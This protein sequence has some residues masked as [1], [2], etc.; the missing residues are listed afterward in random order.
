MNSIRKSVKK[1]VENIFQES[2][3]IGILVGQVFYYLLHKPFR[4]RMT[5]LEM[6]NIGANSVFIVLLTGFFTGMV[7]ALET[8]RIFMRFQAEGTVGSVVAVAVLR[9]IGPVMCS[10][11]IT[12]RAGS[13][14]AA[15]IG[16]M[17]VTQQVD[18]LYTMAVEP[19]S[20]L[21]V[22][23]IIASTLMLPLLTAMFDF[24]AI[25]GSWMVSVKLLSIGE[26]IFFDYI[27]WLVDVED[28]TD[29]L[30]KSCFFGF[31]IAAICCYN[32]LQTE[33]GALGV[34]KSTTRAV[35]MS[36]VLILVSDYFLTSLLF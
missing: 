28:I 9:E 10:L 12:A 15:Q 27:E 13:A 19:V 2:G 35:V 24:I 6:E 7:F 14:M 32:G 11:M 23:R 17:K 18:A 8:G 31:I 30:F 20:Y 36:S 34:G 21:V 5:I 4:I 29:G 25:F 16:T 22:P 33:G 26:G 1:I 3:R